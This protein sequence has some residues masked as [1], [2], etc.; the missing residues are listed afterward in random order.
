MRKK[1]KIMAEVNLRSSQRHGSPMT[2]AV[3]SDFPDVVR[4]VMQ[5]NHQSG[6]PGIDESC[7]MVRSQTKAFQLSR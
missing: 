1:P 7:R 5:M 6:T 2:N 4:D 3:K